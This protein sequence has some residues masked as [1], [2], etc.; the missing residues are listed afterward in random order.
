[1]LHGQK[2]AVVLPA[3]NAAAT[4]RRTY[5]EIPLDI[6]D[7][8]I[9]IDDASRDETVAVA[10]SLGIHTVRHT[11][12]LGYGGNQKTCYRTALDRGA[13]IVVMLHPDY[14]YAPRLVTAMA[15]MIVSGEYDAVL[16]SR[17]LGKG[18]LVGGMPLYKYVA[19]RGLTFVQNILMGQKL[20]EYHSGYRAWS[21]TVL[22]SIALDRCS[23][24]FVF[25]NQMLAQTMHAGF[26]IGEISCPTR[27]FDDAS[28]INFRR[29]CIYGLGVL[30]TA[31]D[32]RLNRFG[33]RSDPLY[34]PSVPAASEPAQVRS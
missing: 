27:Y 7:D 15:S 23:D 28:S 8:V 12:N 26:R 10:Q 21:R 25:D 22:E 5:A 17:I 32:Y 1:M 31:L 29:S 16:A 2:I 6:V 34:S 3:Y 4:L 11:R 20:S 19:N 18:A 33:L 9:L 30:K 24:D 14:Q 13:D